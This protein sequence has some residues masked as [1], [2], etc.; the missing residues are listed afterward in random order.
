L[1]RPP[2]D[3]EP[4]KLGLGHCD[5][6]HVQANHETDKTNSNVNVERCSH[7]TGTEPTRRT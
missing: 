2:N 7:V 4:D 6:A 1:L 3:T 5:G